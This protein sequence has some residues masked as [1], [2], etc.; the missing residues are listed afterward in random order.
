MRGRRRQGRLREQMRRVAEER[1]SAAVA[2]RARA[3]ALA[4][5]ATEAERG[6]RELLEASQRQTARL[7]RRLVEADGGMGAGNEAGLRTD[8]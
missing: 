5:R 6:A 4:A 8:Q 7:H 1:E 3:V 2:D